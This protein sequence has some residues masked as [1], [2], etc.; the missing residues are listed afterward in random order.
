MQARPAL[1]L[2]GRCP[3]AVL[4]QGAGAHRVW[5]GLFTVPALNHGRINTRLMLGLFMSFHSVACGQFPDSLDAQGAGR[6]LPVGSPF[7]SAALRRDP[8]HFHCACTGFVPF[9][10]SDPHA[11]AHSRSAVLL[12]GLRDT[13]ARRTLGPGADEIAQ[14]GT[15]AR[16][17]FTGQAARVSTGCLPVML[18]LR[19]DPPEHPGRSLSS[20]RY[21]GHELEPTRRPRRTPGSAAGQGPRLYP[22]M[23]ADRRGG[24]FRRLPRCRDAASQDIPAGHNRVRPLHV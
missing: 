17:R 20:L 9:C 19:R 13:P 23:A 7:T 2:P 14:E 6:I 24:A 16:H 18:I 5:S 22:V 11:Y 10:T 1:V 4:V 12:P 21:H 15:D 3:R 8:Q